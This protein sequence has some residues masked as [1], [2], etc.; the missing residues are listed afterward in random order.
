MDNYNNSFDFDFSEAVVIRDRMKD[1]E[2]GDVRAA[3]YG[4][5]PSVVSHEKEDGYTLDFVLPL[6][7]GTFNV[8]SEMSDTSTNPVSNATVKEY[9]DKGKPSITMIFANNT[10]KTGKSSKDLLA[11]YDLII[12]YASPSKEG[13]RGCYCIP[14]RFLEDTSTSPMPVL[15]SDNE[16]YSVFMF[17]RNGF[18]IEDYNASECGLIY[19]LYGVKF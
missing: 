5:K 3:T 16:Y 19:A 17:T 2:I 11:N 4:E 13:S 14:I 7:D 9:V 12:C 10:G 15:I 18:Y 8:D 6:P 1:I